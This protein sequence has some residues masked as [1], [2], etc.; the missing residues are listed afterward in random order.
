MTWRA[1][2]SPTVDCRGDMFAGSQHTS[3]FWMKLPQDVDKARH[4]CDPCRNT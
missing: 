2:L 3:I 1:R 4:D